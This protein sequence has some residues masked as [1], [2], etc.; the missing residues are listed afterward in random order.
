MVMMQMCPLRK[1]MQICQ[2]IINI[3]IDIYVGNSNRSI[4]LIHLSMTTCGLGLCELGYVGVKQDKT[5]GQNGTLPK[6]VL[7]PQ[8]LQTYALP[9][10]QLT[11][12]PP[13]QS[14]PLPLDQKKQKESA[15]SISP[16][17]H[18]LSESE[19]YQTCVTT[20]TAVLTSY[21]YKKS[22]LEKNGEE[23]DRKASVKLSANPEST[24]LHPRV[25]ARK[26]IHSACIVLSCRPILKVQKAG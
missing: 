4:S 12:M 9:P 19:H 13:P 5:M 14:L 3:L 8:P 11:T 21:H 10:P 26:W 6:C 15:F 22:L 23:T 7:F 1:K 24:F 2:T 25:S 18:T 17:Q 20:K 16:I